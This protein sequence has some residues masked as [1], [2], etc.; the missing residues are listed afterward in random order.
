MSTPQKIYVLFVAEE[1]EIFGCY[2]TLESAVACGMKHFTRDFDWCVLEKI[3]D[4]TNPARH[5]TDKVYE[6]A[7]GVCS[8]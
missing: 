7:Y 2:S 4:D 3:L 6:C 8:K 5:Y 1:S